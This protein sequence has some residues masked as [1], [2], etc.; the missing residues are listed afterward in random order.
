MSDSKEEKLKIEQF[1]LEDYSV[2]WNRHRDSVVVFGTLIEDG[3]HFVIEGHPTNPGTLVRV[4]K[5]DAIHTP[6]N[7]TS[8]DKNGKNHNVHKIFIN[9]NATV[10]RTSY[11]LIDNLVS[12]ERSLNLTTHLQP[13]S[14]PF[15]GSLNHLYPG[16]IVRISCN[17]TYLLALLLILIID[18]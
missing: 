3:E 10:S 8:R 4:S 17:S 2:E 1:S 11:D 15:P 7:M 18:G 13:P 14:P 9:K 16:L 5:V 6:T 12:S